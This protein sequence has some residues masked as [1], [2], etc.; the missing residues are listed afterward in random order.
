MQII[1][2]GHQLDVPDSL[3]HYIEQKGAR[4][5]EH[6]G[7]FEKMQ[8]ILTALHNPAERFEAE[9][10]LHAPRHNDLVATAQDADLRKATDAALDRIERQLVKLKEKM[11]DKRSKGAG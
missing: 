9:V 5:H 3:R 4:L 11:K 1:V 7:L 6:V 8:V 2:S 10:T